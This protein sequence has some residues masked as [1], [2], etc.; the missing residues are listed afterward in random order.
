[1]ALV[2]FVVIICEVIVAFCIFQ[3]SCLSASP[4]CISEEF[5]RCK[6]DEVLDRVVEELISE[7]AFFVAS[8][9]E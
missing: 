1:V 6:V 9:S 4:S 5:L 3:S 2:F 8:K 7:A